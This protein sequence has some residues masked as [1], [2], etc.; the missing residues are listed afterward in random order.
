MALGA[1]LT[2]LYQQVLTARFGEVTITP[3]VKPNALLLVGRPENVKMAVELIQ[4]LDVPVAP[5]TR[6]EVFPLKNASATEAKTMIDQFLNQAP[7][8]ETEQPA[9]GGAAAGTVDQSTM[10]APRRWWWPTC[11][12]TRSS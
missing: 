12:R 1:L 11:E 9:A 2:R 5:T 7:T 8:A 6:F 10:L 3:L 4:R